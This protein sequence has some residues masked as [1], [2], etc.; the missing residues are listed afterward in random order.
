[1]KPYDNELFSNDVAPLEFTPP[2]EED[3]LVSELKST[4]QP[5]ATPQYHI[6]AGV[7]VARHFRGNY[8]YYVVNRNDVT[9][10]TSMSTVTAEELKDCIHE[11]LHT[12]S[13]CS[14]DVK[15][16]VS[17]RVLIS[18]GVN[19]LDDDRR[20][21]RRRRPNIPSPSTSGRPSE[22]RK[23][24]C[25]RV[26]NSGGEGD[27]LREES[28]QVAQPLTRTNVTIHD[29]IWSRDVTD[30]GPDSQVINALH[31]DDVVEPALSQN[32]TEAH[33][34]LVR[35]VLPESIA[36]DESASE[37]S[38]SSQDTTVFNGVTNATNVAKDVNQRTSIPLNNGYCDSDNISVGHISRTTFDVLPMPTSGESTPPFQRN[39]TTLKIKIG[40][41]LTEPTPSTSDSS[42]GH[43][44]LEQKST[45]VLFVH[46]VKSGRTSK[47]P[48]EDDDG[49]ESTDNMSTGSNNSL[50]STANVSAVG[51]GV[52]AKVAPQNIVKS[53]IMKSSATS[54]IVNTLKTKYVVEGTNVSHVTL[55]K[56]IASKVDLANFNSIKRTDDG[57]RIGRKSVL[58][59]I[60][61]FSPGKPLTSTVKSYPESISTSTVPSTNGSIQ[62]QETSRTVVQ[63]HFIKPGDVIL[64]Y[65]RTL[66][67]NNTDSKITPTDS[68]ITLTDIKNKND[69]QPTTSKPKS[70]LK[71]GKSWKSVTFNLP[72]PHGD[73]VSDSSLDYQ[74]GYNDCMQN[75]VFNESELDDAAYSQGIQEEVC[76]TPDILHHVKSSIFSEKFDEQDKFT[77]HLAEQPMSFTDKVN[78]LQRGSEQIVEELEKACSLRN[79]SAGYSA[80]HDTGTSYSSDESDYV[81]HS[82]V[83]EMYQDTIPE[84]ELTLHPHT[85]DNIEIVHQHLQRNSRVREVEDGDRSEDRISIWNDPDSYY[86]SGT[87]K[88]VLPVEDVSLREDHVIPDQYINT[89]DRYF[90]LD[91]PRKSRFSEEPPAVPLKT[92]TQDDITIGSPFMNR[93]YQFGGSIKNK[94]HGHMPV[95]H[96]YAGVHRHPADVS[97][98]FTDYSDTS[99]VTHANILAQKR[100]RLER[101][102][103]QYDELLS[104]TKHNV[105]N[106]DITVTPKTSDPTQFVGRRRLFTDGKV[107]LHQPVQQQ[108]CPLVA[109][110]Y[111]ANHIHGTTDTNSIR[112]QSLPRRLSQYQHIHHPHNQSSTS[113]HTQPADHNCILPSKHTHGNL[114]TGMPSTN[115]SHRPHK[116]DGHYVRFA[117]TSDIYKLMQEHGKKTQQIA[118]EQQRPYRAYY[119]QND[120][121]V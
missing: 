81:N 28:S 31:P 11:N 33:G 42:S 9:S 97:C 75:Y 36:S 13:Q 103:L 41:E 10:C 85:R 115:S 8:D 77:R 91:R 35:Q 70:I 121:S 68:N 107:H 67:L 83:Q 43:I 99:Y 22:S 29:R 44:P 56:T 48:H 87:S 93:R 7:S 53:S 95:Y 54:P 57:L 73:C 78:H 30:A 47:A 51:T 3:K 20:I 105:G 32:V 18:T 74:D 69:K 50:S 46:K 84:H 62:P 113:T 120:T 112:T 24:V 108:N 34:D 92:H 102:R 79:D 55:T 117:T 89:R 90:S 94:Q 14:E 76:P 40:Q 58:E 23:L 39:C 66:A 109:E 88:G 106:V 104:H 6:Y 116:G 114:P 72:E 118:R 64:S 65:T 17:G 119:P 100:N 4:S 38:F 15:H 96:S 52:G 26:D 59:S 5:G 16:M 49:Y 27:G 111:Q 2:Y 25:P 80:G 37:C 110:E 98:V 86:T 19:T 61:R 71:K 63:E 1:M 101:E 45:A 21:T 12:S 60:K 82:A